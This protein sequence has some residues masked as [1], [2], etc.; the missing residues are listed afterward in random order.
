MSDS[1]PSAEE[2]ERERKREYMR[3]WR[4]KNREYR[5]GTAKTSKQREYQ[6]KWYI[7]NREQVL[8]QQKEHRVKNRAG[9]LARHR[10]YYKEWRAKNREKVR[11]YGKAQYAKNREKMREYRLK[12]K[13]G[14]D[15]IAWDALF[16][17]QGNCC[18]SCGSKDPKS[19]NGWETDHDHETNKV[20]AILCKSCNVLIG[21]AND[22]P[23]VCELAA[24]FLRKHGKG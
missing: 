15:E 6:H 22:D 17:S 4:A 16:L 1:K 18:G 2:K 10:E 19:K 7:K 13:Y 12:R 8:A 5:R 20:R 24:A 14:M 21:L 23:I 9:V 3:T 11:A